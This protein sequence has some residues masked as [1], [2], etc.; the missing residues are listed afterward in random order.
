MKAVVTA[1]EQAMTEF[2]SVMLEE[3][4]IAVI[5]KVILNLV[6]QSGRWNS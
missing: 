2:N 5:T 1:I 3:A 4:K 6:E